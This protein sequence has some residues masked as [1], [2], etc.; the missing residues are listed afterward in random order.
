MP[1][2]KSAQVFSRQTLV[3]ITSQQSFDR[4]RNIGGQATVANRTRDRR[5]RSHRAAH[6]EVVSILHAAI[7]FDF[8]AFKS[9]VGNP[10]LAAAIGAAGYVQFQMLFESRQAFF[11]FLDQPTGKVFGLGDG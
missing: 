3:E 5:M 1:R 2:E 10:V 8:L 11:E 4:V 6:A 7:D 9:E